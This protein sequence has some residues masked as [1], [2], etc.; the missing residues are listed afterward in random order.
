MGD[1]ILQAI[2]LF[3]MIFLGF[4]MKRVGILQKTI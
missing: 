1:I 4:I 2:S 3:F